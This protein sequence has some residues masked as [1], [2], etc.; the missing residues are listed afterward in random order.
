V[1]LKDGWIVD[2]THPV[3]AGAEPSAVR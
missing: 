1:N 2:E 3:Q